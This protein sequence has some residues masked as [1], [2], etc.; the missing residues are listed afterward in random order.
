[1]PDEAEKLEIPQ[2]LLD[3]LRTIVSDF[4]KEDESVYKAQ[5]KIFRRNE[6]FWHGLQFIFWNEA[7]GDWRTPSAGTL[8][9]FQQE[10]GEN[11]PLYD[12][13]INIYKAHGVSIL[14]AVT[15]RLPFTH[16]PPDNPDEPLDCTTSRV[17]SKIAELIQRHNRAKLLFV[18]AWFLLYVQGLV[19]AYNYHKSDPK[20]GTAKVDKMAVQDAKIS[21]DRY[22]CQ[23]CGGELPSNSPP[24]PTCE[25]MLAPRVEVGPTE[26]QVVKVGTVEVPKG[27]E[28][29][30]VFGPMNVKIPYYARSQAD[31]GYLFHYLEQHYC[32]L[33]QLFPDFVEELGPHTGST[34]QY[35][36]W[37]R[38]P[39]TFAS[40]YSGEEGSFL[41][42]TRR[43]W[44]RPWTFERL[45]KSHEG[46]KAELLK[47]FPDGVKVTLIGEHIVEVRSENLDDVW[48]ITPSGASS[49]LHTDPLGQPLIPIQEMVNTLANLS[50]Q[51]IEF[52]IPE[53]FADPDVLDFDQ[54]DKHEASPGY[55]YPAKAARPGDE[56]SKGFY[57]LP[58][59]SLSRD[60]PVLRDRLDKDAQFVVGSFPSIYGGPSEGKSRTYAEYNMSRAMAL[61]RLQNPWEMMSDWWGRVM[62]KSVRSYVRH[63]IEDERLVEK[64]KDGGGYINVWIRRAELT[65]KVGEV[66]PEVTED[67]PI[68]AGQKRDLLLKLIELN[69]EYV[70]AAL[71]HPENAKNIAQALA[72]VDF[73]IPGDDQRLKQ[74]AEIKE[75]LTSEPDEGDGGEPMSAVP[76]DPDIDDHAVHVQVLRSFLA[77]PEGLEIRKTNP[78]G[79]MNCMYHLKEHMMAL[80]LQTAGQYEGTPPG[81]PPET[82]AP[83]TQG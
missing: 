53:T 24:C 36:R 30:D 27:R 52:G 50:I 51:T 9:D 79:F 35:G 20:Y 11:I 25:S 23:D 14:G 77:S 4:E 26:K 56:L 1:M 47:R 28:L 55:I 49:Y 64:D 19:A 80:Q 16:F 45:D 82:E 62:D 15:A 81:E 10:T 59:A 5:L 72:F 76:I 44:L 39:V 41:L 21:P 2:E 63:M 29:I 22:F 69:N 71:Y 70:N 40:V 38:N 54:Y 74:R 73:Y 60:V 57:T 68:S 8:A 6:E 67:L 66:E 31:C 46:E 17:F 13:V 3:A 75:M 48:T 58:K 34:D 61:Q 33:R 78:A 37:A 32:L 83:S 12:Y 42:T 65:G 18:R 43:C 7:V